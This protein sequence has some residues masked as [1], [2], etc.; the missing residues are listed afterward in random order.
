HG[1][2]RLGSN[3]LLDLVVFGRSAAI[4]CAE[5]ITPGSSPKPLA[6]DAC[7][8][9]LARFDRIRHAKGNRSTA[10]IRLEMQKTMQTKAAVFRTQSTL[11]E[12]IAMMAAT[13]ASF[14]DVRIDD[15]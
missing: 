15:R 5:L 14:S 8:Q 7:D 13:R 11:D 3:S 1:A 9:A 12:G 4:R 10:E 6:K 2:N